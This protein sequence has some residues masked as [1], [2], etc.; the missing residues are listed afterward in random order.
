[1]YLLHNKLGVSKVSLEHQPKHMHKLPKEKKH[2][3]S[4]NQTCM[5]MY[6]PLKGAEVTCVNRVQYYY[7]HTCVQWPPLGNGKVT[8]VYRVAAIYRSTLQKI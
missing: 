6:I 4:N 1:M 7:S 8:L 5:F 2:K 3:T